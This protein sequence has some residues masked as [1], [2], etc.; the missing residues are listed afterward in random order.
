M[1]LTNRTF[2]TGVVPARRNSRFDLVPRGSFSRGSAPHSYR[3]FVKEVKGLKAK[4]VAVATLMLAVMISVPIAYQNYAVQAVD[5]NIRVGTKLVITSI[6]G[7]AL[8]RNN[9]THT[10]DLKTASLEYHVEVTE[11]TLE[12]YSFKVTSGAI[13]VDGVTH[14]ILKGYGHVVDNDAKHI[15]FMRGHVRGTDPGGNFTYNCSGPLTKIDGRTIGSMDGI[16]HGASGEKFK[17][18]WV[19]ESRL[20]T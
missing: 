8:F 20:G 4:T 14:T 11:V 6:T 5:P 17:I 7:V 2:K 10:V 16:F 1:K 3:L 15:T 13:T 19:A 18:D 12:G 9:S